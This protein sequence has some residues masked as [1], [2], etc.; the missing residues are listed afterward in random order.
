MKYTHAILAIILLSVST[1]MH[2]QSKTT[3][4]LSKR[5]NDAMALF[6]Y[7]N[8]L[9][10]LNQNNDKDF[11]DLIK[12]V[13]KMRFL[14]INKTNSFSTTDYKK[15]VSGYEQESFEAIMTSRHEGK[16]FNVYIKE[17]EHKTKGMLILVN[18]STKLYILD[19][20]GS[21]P[22]NKVTSLYNSI[23]HN[24]EIAKKIKA[25]AG[26]HGDDKNFHKN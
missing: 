13:E 23:D 11:D 22:L 5:Y 24:S 12:D 14:M 17:K 1:C 6:F 4:A 21:I 15:I 7:N 25:F 8:T 16:S 18:D 20:L 3:E 19:I 2:A 26:D 10:M 9:R